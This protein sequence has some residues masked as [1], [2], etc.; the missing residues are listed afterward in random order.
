MPS[1]T[2]CVMNS[3]NIHFKHADGT[4]NVKLLVDT[5]HMLFAQGNSIK[6]VQDFSERLAHV[7]CKDIRKKKYISFSN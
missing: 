5:G 6:L 2:T 1:T 4:T 7:H 3:E